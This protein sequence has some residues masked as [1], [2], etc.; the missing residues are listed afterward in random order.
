MS[1]IFAY[2]CWT[3]EIPYPNSTMVI[4]FGPTR[5]SRNELADAVSNETRES[6]PPDAVLVLCPQDF[7]QAVREDLADQTVMAPVG[8]GACVGLYAYDT[9]GTLTKHSEEG[10]DA[11]RLPLDYL[12]RQGLTVLFSKRGGLVETDP[13]SHFVKPSGSIDSRF[14]R[15]S[16]A[17]SEGAEIFFCAYWL[18]PKLQSDVEYIHLD[19]S[20]IASIAFAATMMKDN[21]VRPVITTFHSYD[22]LDS[23][24]FVQDRADMVLISASQSGNMYTKLLG[25]V[26]DHTRIITLFSLA[27]IDN[28]GQPVLCDLRFDERRNILGYHPTLLPDLAATRPIKLIGEHFVAQAQHPRTTIP[29]VAHRP[30]VVRAVLAKLAGKQVFRAFRNSLVEKEERGVW[31]DVDALVGTSLFQ[32]WIDHTLVRRIPLV[33]AAVIH[34]DDDGP[35][36]TVTDQAMETVSRR[37]IVLEPARVKSLSTAIDEMQATSPVIDDASPVV[38]VGG[39]TGR[40]SELLAASRTLREYAPKSYRI[41]FAAA[42]MPFSDQDYDLLEANLCYPSHEFH[43]LVKLCLDRLILRESWLDERE[44]LQG[45]EDELPS[46]LKKRLKDL[47]TTSEGLLDNLFLARNGKTK[48]QLRRNFAF[49]PDTKALAKVSQVDVFVTMAAV[50][51]N[52][53]TGQQISEEERLRNDAYTHTVLSG[54]TFSRYNDGI[55]QAAILRA[56]CP[57]ELNYRDAPK[58]S[59]LIYDLIRQMVLLRQQ[60]QGEALC[61]FLIALCTGRLKLRMEDETNLITVLRSCGRRGTAAEKWLMKACQNAISSSNRE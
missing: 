9:D 4:F 10:P 24:P 41:Y 15:A 37:G 59:Y 48:L 26:K 28:N 47:R 34:L 50:L 56:A 8:P 23:H 60:P 51:E 1:G 58:D 13:T 5:Y 12:R 27:D 49:W 20:G 57:I 22:G 32:D 45:Y 25:K 11:A 43:V 2:R 36:K 39:V 61:E 40:G 18:L 38:V 42:A 19:T 21:N 53:R 33:T 7:S 35:A 54:E 29:G 6:L 55:I 17:L 16:Y 14:L 3:P 46:P 30:T 31:I 52:M 44:L